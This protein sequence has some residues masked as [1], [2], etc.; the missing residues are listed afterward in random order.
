MV[1]MY[2]GFLIHSSTDGHLGCFHVLAS[3]NSCSHEIKRRLLLGS[4]VMTTLDN[5][6]KSRNVTLPTKVHLVKAMVFPV[7]MYGCDSWTIKKT[8]HW[9]IDA[10]EVWCWR[11]L[12]RVPWTAGRSNQSFLKE[13]SPEYSLEGLMLKLKPQSFGHLMGRTDLLEKTLMLG[14][15]EGRRR[16]QQR[17]RWLDGIPNVMDMNLSKLQELVID[18][19]AWLAA[20]HDVARVEHDWATELNLT[21]VNYATIQSW[22]MP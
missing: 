9:R 1:Y 7:V 2:H 3:I 6:F 18:R 14:K 22:P 13:I 4:K 12:L 10:F 11:R 16:R 8:E 21:S 17:V 20:V 19:E 5:I 15:I